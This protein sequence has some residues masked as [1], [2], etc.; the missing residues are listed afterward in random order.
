MGSTSTSIAVPVC[1]YYIVDSGVRGGHVEWGYGRIGLSVSKLSW[2]WG[3]S[4]TI[5]QIGHG[6]GVAGA[7]AGATFG[8]AKDATIHS[9]RVEDG[10]G[11]PCPDGACEEDLIAGI[12]WVA[13]NRELP[14]VMNVSFGGVPGS[15]G[16]RNA[17]EGAIA[18]GVIAIKSA[19]NE[20]VD[21]YQN[22]ANRARG[23]IV[24]GA[25][26]QNDTRS[27]FVGG[28][29]SNYGS[30]VTVFGP[31]SRIKSA[32]KNSDTDTLSW[33]GTSFAA[34]L[35]AGIVALLLQQEP[36]AS[37]SRIRDV[38][39]RASTNGVL[40]NIGSGSPNRLVYSKILTSAYP[41]P[42]IPPTPP[43][44]SGPDLVRQ[45]SNCL[46]SVAPGSAPEPHTYAWYQDGV[47]QP[48]TS[49]FYRATAGTSS[50]QLEL[51]LVDGTG[52]THWTYK[53]V[54]VSSSAN[55]CLDS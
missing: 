55:E 10:G 5:D 53:Y 34:P 42:P 49:A 6:T 24:V 20:N 43:G 11:F 38:L 3:A 31:G 22:R 14:A 19:G 39:I 48:E 1:M 7:A 30:L 26:N 41:L 25:S 27:M 4:P 17:L 21:A 52:Q 35:T 40:G 9:V 51:N 8:I 50:F 37:Q 15:F 45:Y 46:Y 29:G 32:N 2:S 23:L 33:S 18:A 47:L 44:I 12:D 16:V 54:S 28:G 36:Y 13:G